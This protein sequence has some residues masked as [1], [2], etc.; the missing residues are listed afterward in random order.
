MTNRNNPWSSSTTP[1]GSRSLPDALI[2]SLGLGAPLPELVDRAAIA[3]DRL[4]PAGFALPAK[5]APGVRS[6]QAVSTVPSVVRLAFSG[7]DVVVRRATRSDE[8]ADLFARNAAHVL[9]LELRADDSLVYVRIDWSAGVAGRSLDW[10]E[11]ARRLG[12][13][14][15]A[16]RTHSDRSM[17]MQVLVGSAVRA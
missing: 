12:W 1:I 16:T 3:R 10:S 9:G 14:E 6:K 4:S 11:V 15:V 8:L 2:E 7:R 5:L 13:Q 17:F